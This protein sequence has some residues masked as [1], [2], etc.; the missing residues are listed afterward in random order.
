M[1]RQDGLTAL[2]LAVRARDEF[3]AC[4][5]VKHG[6]TVDVP[7]GPETVT[8]LHMAATIGLQPVV[9]TL[10]QVSFCNAKSPVIRF[11]Y[12]VL[13]PISIGQM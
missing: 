2:H 9:R 4:F 6:A 11:I 10:L 3:S 7:A 13:D 12:F 5:L 8:A 1:G